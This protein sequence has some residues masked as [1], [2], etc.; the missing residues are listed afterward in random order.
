[1]SDHGN[2]RLTAANLRKMADAVEKLA[3]VPATV[4]QI[5]CGAIL[6]DVRRHDDQREGTRYVVTGIRVMTGGQ[7]DEN[8]HADPWRQ[9]EDRITRSPRP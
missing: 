2:L 7:F 5:T 8:V 4:T 3:T 1:M 6:L 9:D